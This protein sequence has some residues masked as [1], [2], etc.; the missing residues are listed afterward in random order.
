MVRAVTCGFKPRSSQMFFSL[1]GCRGI[2]KLKIWWSIIDWCYHSLNNLLGAITGL[3]KHSLGLKNHNNFIKD[4]LVFFF[5]ISFIF[6][7]FCPFLTES[8]ISTKTR[9]TFLMVEPTMHEWR[10]KSS[11]GK[12]SLDFF[13]KKSLLVHSFILEINYLGILL[14]LPASNSLRLSLGSRGIFLG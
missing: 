4:V 8:A 3:S 1:L 5:K 2:K 9:S 13:R 14:S 11:Q 10:S 7:V 12:S 6:R